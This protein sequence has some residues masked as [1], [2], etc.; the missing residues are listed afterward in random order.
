MSAYPHLL[1][2]YYFGFLTLRNRAVMGAMHTRL[3]PW[4]GRWSGSRRFIANA[5]AARPA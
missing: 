2:P 1:A 4:T 5:P 3:E